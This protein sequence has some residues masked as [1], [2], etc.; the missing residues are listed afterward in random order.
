MMI[1]AVQ[2][3]NSKCCQGRLT[4]DEPMRAGVYGLTLPEKWVGG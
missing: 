4:V 3:D 2:D 1:A